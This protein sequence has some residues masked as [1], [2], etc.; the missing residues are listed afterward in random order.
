MTFKNINEASITLIAAPYYSYK[1]DNVP[2]SIDVALGLGS[3]VN[4]D[5][6]FG[7][8]IGGYVGAAYYLKSSNT[9]LIIGSKLGFDML[10]VDLHS[11]ECS[12]DGVFYVTPVIGVG[13]C[14]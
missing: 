14:Y 3:S 8:G 9:A 1:L 5:K 13:F 6:N 12:F 11:G 2:M 10:S 4:I 7:L